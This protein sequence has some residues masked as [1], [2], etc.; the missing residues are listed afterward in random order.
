MEAV[1]VEEEVPLVVADLEEDE[2]VELE[3]VTGRERDTVVLGVL[4][5]VAAVCSIFSVLIPVA[6]TAFACLAAKLS[7]LI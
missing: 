4:E 7:S 6:E 1:T 3:D 5:A 2:E